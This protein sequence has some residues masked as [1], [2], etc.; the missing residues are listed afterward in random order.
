MRGRI[1]LDLGKVS[2]SAEI[3]VNGERAGIKLAPPYRVDISK[4]VK[5]GANRIE[6]LVYSA[7]MNHYQTIPTR[8]RKQAPSGLLGPVELVIEA[9]E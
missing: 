2:A 8:Y 3:R 1:W 4:L 7:L 9:D 5:S 6:V